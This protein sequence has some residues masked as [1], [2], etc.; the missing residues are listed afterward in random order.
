MAVTI[1]ALQIPNII[2]L[3]F[4]NEETVLATHVGT[5]AYSEAFI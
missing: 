3:Q 4:S 1:I 2:T 5:K